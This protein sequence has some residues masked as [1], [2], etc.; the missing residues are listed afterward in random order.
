MLL[1]YFIIILRTDMEAM[2]P[3]IL[4][5]SSIEVYPTFKALAAVYAISLT[6][7]YIRVHAV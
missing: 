7:T 6:N 4:K 1:H 3:R 5:T 2:P